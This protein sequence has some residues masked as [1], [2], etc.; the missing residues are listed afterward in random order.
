M[1][2]ATL[3]TAKDITCWQSLCHFAETLELEAIKLLPPWGVDRA[4]DGDLVLLNSLSSNRL[5]YV[6]LWQLSK[7]VLQEMSTA[8]VLGDGSAKPK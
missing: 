4:A 2:S 8:T 7:E 5:P 3:V 1:E 6:P